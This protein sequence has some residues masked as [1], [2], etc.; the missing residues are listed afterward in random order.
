MMSFIICSLHYDSDEIKEDEM[1]GHA[2][3]IGGMRNTYKVLVRN[4]ERKRPVG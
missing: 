3:H 2:A 1:D 4:P